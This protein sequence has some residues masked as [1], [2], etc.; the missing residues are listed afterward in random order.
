MHD[1]HKDPCK[2][3]VVNAPAD[4]AE[5]LNVRPVTQIKIEIETSAV[6]QTHTS[7]AVWAFSFTFTYPPA[8]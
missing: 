6:K 3:K 7:M 5:A 2:A 4:Q 8:K 1:V